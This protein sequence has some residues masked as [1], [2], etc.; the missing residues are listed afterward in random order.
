MPIQ[1]TTLNHRLTTP[2]K[3]FEAMAAGVPVVAS[4]L[5][6]MAAIVRETGCGLLV[7][8]TDPAAMAAADRARCSRRRPPSAGAIGR[9]ACEAPS[10]VQLGDPGGD[11]A[12]GVRP[13]D[14]TP[15]VTGVATARRAVILV[16]GPAAPYSRALRIARPSWRDGL[17]GRDRGHRGSRTAR[18]ESREGELADPALRAEWPLGGVGRSGAGRPRV[19]RPARP[20]AAPG[21]GPPL[22]PLAAHRARLVGPSPASS[23]RPTSTTPVAA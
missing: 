11:P 23:P 8:P 5:P 15:M 16:G 12:G 17:P 18:A 22:A 19:A 7:D 3:L 2:N 13:A 4:D 6:G 14:G 20:P 21:D 1:P 10:H 9:R